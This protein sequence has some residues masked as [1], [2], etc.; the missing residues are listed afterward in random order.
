MRLFLHNLAVFFFGGILMQVCHGSVTCKLRNE[1][2]RIHSL[3]ARPSASQDG[4]VGGGR[5]G[6]L[7]PFG[8]ASAALTWPDAP[9]FN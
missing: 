9:P 3:H 1:N 6:L 5:G 8:S 7:T 4:P 2:R